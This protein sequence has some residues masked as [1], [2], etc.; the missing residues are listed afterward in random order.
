MPG[1]RKKS[2]R[3]IKATAPERG[4]KSAGKKNATKK[5]PAPA[6]KAWLAKEPTTDRQK[7]LRGAAAVAIGLQFDLDGGGRERELDDVTRMLNQEIRSLDVESVEMIGD[8]SIPLGSKGVSVALIGG[9]IVKLLSSDALKN[10]I[11]AVR[12]WASRDSGR[13]AKLVIGGNSIEIANITAQQQ[14]HLIETFEAQVLAAGSGKR[15]G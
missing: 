15:N 13:S 2:S 6:R 3:A 9:L 1:S 4:V 5:K 10:V 14:Q 8:G 12:A 7:R 11:A